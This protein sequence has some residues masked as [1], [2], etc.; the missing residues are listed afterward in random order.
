MDNSIDM[1]DNEITNEVTKI[2]KKKKFKLNKQKIAP[3]VF[4]SPFFIIFAA[5]MIFP[6]GYSIFLSFQKWSGMGS[7]QFVGLKNFF[8]LIFQDVY[9]WKTIGITIWLL[10]FGSLS[11]HAIAI[12]LAIVLNSRLIKGRDLFRTAYFLPVITSS[13]SV[14]I[15]FQNVF[16]MKYGLL[17]FVTG[18]FGAAPVDWVN[19][20]WSIPIAIAIV[21]NWRWIGWNTLIYLAGL[22]SIPKELYESADIDGASLVRK[23]TSITIPMILPIIFFAVTMS[24]VG[25]M[26]VF[27][28]PFVLTQGYLWMG[29]ANNAGFTAAFYI[30]WSLQRAGKYGRGS[31]VAWLLFILVLIMT[32]VNRAVTDYYKGDRGIKHTKKQQKQKIEEKLT[33]RGSLM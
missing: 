23:H 32:F 18:L 22:Q 11:Q 1:A 12:P 33:P 8:F 16:N 4:I 2:I 27:D 30:L 25:G 15:I 29:G 26:Q 20:S 6:L 10:V 24:I 14:A 21:I 28:E 7:M 19:W 31:A 3:Y 13:V 17:N 9:F 5:F